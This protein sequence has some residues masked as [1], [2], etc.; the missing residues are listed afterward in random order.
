MFAR[1]PKEFKIPFYVKPQI[2]YEKLTVELNRNWIIDCTENIQSYDE[3][4]IL[5]ISNEYDLN[6][7]SFNPYA[8][9]LECDLDREDNRDPAVLDRY[10][11]PWILFECDEAQYGELQAHQEIN[12][13]RDTQKKNKHI[14]SKKQ[15]VTINNR[16][17]SSLKSQ[18]ETFY[19]EIV[20]DDMEMKES[21]RELNAIIIDKSITSEQETRYKFSEWN[22]F[23]L[24]RAWFRGMSAFY[25]GKFEH[26][27]KAWTKSKNSYKKL[28]MKTLVL[29]FIKEQFKSPFCESELLT[30]NNFYDCV[31]AVLHSHRHKKNDDFIKNCDFSKIRKVLYSFSTSAKHAFLT[32]N[33]Y[34][35]IF[36]NFYDVE[37]KNFIRAR[38]R[39]KST[40]FKQELQAEL[41][42][43][44]SL[45]KETLVSS[46]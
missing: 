15:R 3:D 20:K 22:S 10:D 39:N 24:R 33:W 45:A 28:T 42:S 7:Q 16:K 4:G 21:E 31:T 8:L 2:P 40:E 27:Y 26:I 46:E 6:D 23:S 17:D 1:H 19:S 13:V 38:S 29:N 18:G 5:Q 14:K 32:D 30:N 9:Q 11:Q 37:S 41:D 34:A 43:L 44:Y 12:N 36:A 25:K 35:L